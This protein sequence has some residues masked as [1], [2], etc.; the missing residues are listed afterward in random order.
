MDRAAVGDV[1]PAQVPFTELFAAG[2]AGRPLHLVGLDQEPTPVP[3]DRWSGPVDDGDLAILELCDG[4]TLDVGCGPGR[5]S[6]AL[7]ARGR[8]VLGIDVVGRAVDQTR[9]RGAAALERNVFATMPAEGRWGTALLADGNIGIG[10]DPVALL[11]RLAQLVHPAGRI[12]VEVA[13]PGVETRTVW[14]SLDA[15]P[16]R[17][18][19][20]R[21]AVVGV[22]GIGSVAAESGLGTDAVLDVGDRWCAVLRSAA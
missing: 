15:G 19:P 20:F 4:P 1:R 2:L 10:G 11:R 8:I 14:A 3:V 18:R 13:A 22:D 9:Q 6:A 5:M 17:S 16:V 12:V 7:A 21:W